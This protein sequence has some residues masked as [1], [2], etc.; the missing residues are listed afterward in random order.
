MINSLRIA[1]AATAAWLV[2][3]C[4]VPLSFAESPSEAPLNCPQ[5]MQID[6]TTICFP[7]YV[8]KLN[9]F[10]DF[11]KERPDYS[12]SDDWHCV[13]SLECNPTCPDKAGNP[14]KGECRRWPP[15][16]VCECIQARGICQWQCGESTKDKWECKNLG[17]TACICNN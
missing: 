3:L 16:R 4:V 12:C 11:S 6:D 2:W 1:G 9:Y 8:S 17:P 15:M 7:D 5:S 10:A 14:P 13:A